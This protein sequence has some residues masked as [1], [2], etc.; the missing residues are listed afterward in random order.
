MSQLA[1]VTKHHLWHL[2]QT[3]K[4]SECQ[5][6]ENTIHHFFLFLDQSHKSLYNP[7]HAVVPSSQLQ[8]VGADILLPLAGQIKCEKMWTNRSNQ[9]WCEKVCF[10]PGRDLDMSAVG[11]GDTQIVT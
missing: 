6:L 11:S 7:A 2:G 5:L 1:I 4:K 9:K 3:T 8:I 10:A